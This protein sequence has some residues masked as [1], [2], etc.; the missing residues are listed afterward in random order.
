MF[1]LIL[2]EFLSLS[3][4]SQL[5]NESPRTTRML[6]T[7]ALSVPCSLSS[8]LLSTHM[9]HVWFAAVCAESPILYFPSNSHLS[10]QY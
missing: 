9:L 1:A 3:F 10:E 4:P 5:G 6:C 8:I 7:L 2:Y